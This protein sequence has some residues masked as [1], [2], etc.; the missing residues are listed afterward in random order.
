[1]KK[2]AS[3]YFT[4]LCGLI[5]FRRIC[6]WWARC[7]P[8]H[9]LKPSNGGG[10]VLT[11]FAVAPKVAPRLV[12]CLMCGRFVMAS[13]NA[14]ALGQGGDLGPAGLSVPERTP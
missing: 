7:P 4:G 2:A 9:F 5:G 13:Q 14:L 1:M 3:L 6:K 11:G 8:N 10:L 12:R